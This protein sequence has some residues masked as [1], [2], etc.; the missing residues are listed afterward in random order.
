M[1]NDECA[2]LLTHASDVAEAPDGLSCAQLV[3]TRL[4]RPVPRDA[5]FRKAL[6]SRSL[7]F[8]KGAVLNTALPFPRNALHPLFHSRNPPRDALRMCSIAT[9]AFA[10]RTAEPCE[11]LYGEDERS[12]GGPSTERAL[13]TEARAHQSGELCALVCVA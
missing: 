8:S 2:A 11:G 6:S 9:R 3:R 13:R 4:H 12:D 5:L 7:S 1:A 10:L